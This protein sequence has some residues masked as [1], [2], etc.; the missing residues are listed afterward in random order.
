MMMIPSFILFFEKSHICLVK[1]SKQVISIYLWKINLGLGSA[2]VSGQT[3]LKFG[4]FGGVQKD[5]KFSFSWVSW[6]WVSSKLEVRLMK[7]KVIQSNSKFVMIGFDPS[8]PSKKQWKIKMN[9][10]N[11]VACSHFLFWFHY[12][13]NNIGIKF[14]NCKCVSKTITPTAINHRII[15]YLHT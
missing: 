15:E 4:L 8:L 10:E 7:S 6:V 12:Y 3:G 11:V 13:E 9:I 2:P 14:K 5:L 1:V